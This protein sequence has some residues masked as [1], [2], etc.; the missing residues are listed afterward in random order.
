[1][2]TSSRRDRH[3]RGLRGP[4][5]PS[6]VPLARTRAQRFDDYVL[7]AVEDLERRLGEEL[8]GVEFAVEDVPDVPADP[9][10]LDPDGI[11]LGRLVPARGKEPARVVVYR[12]PVEAR[13]DPD[14]VRDLVREVVVEYVATH[15]GV[16][17]ESIDP[18]AG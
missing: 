15:L 5:A 11:P 8:S 17:P 6:T 4:L 2:P 10:E 12:R 18:D 3:G 9:A 1:V 7:D 13:A 14:Q 16:D